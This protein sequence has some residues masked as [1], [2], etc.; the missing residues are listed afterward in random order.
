MMLSDTMFQITLAF[1]CVAA[2]LYLWSLVGGPNATSRG[3]S[4]LAGAGLAAQT[5]AIVLR[6]LETGHP[7]FINLFE[8]L[9][10]VTWALVAIYL[11]TERK[12]KIGGLGAFV[13]TVALVAIVCGSSLP[14]GV[15]A[16]LMAAI[17][18]R[19]SS[20]HIASC[21]FSYA[22]FALAF[23]AAIGYILQERLLKL[24]RLT[25]FQQHL[26]SLDMMDRFAYRM[27]AL[28]FPMLT[29]GVVT[30]A[31][32]ARTAWGDYWSWD[33]KETWSLVTWLVYAAY[34]HVRIVQGW[35]G[36]W[37][38]RLI[39]A[40]FACM[41]MTYFGVSFLPRGLHRYNW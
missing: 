34:L 36:K 40:G 31:M 18:N 22:S 41:L 2:A 1:Y 19:W 15:S 3:A 25:V 21:L 39:I 14:R 35:R 5:I 20:I 10:V 28:G 24:R 33:P 32:W 11:A 7:P 30:G 9:T 23:A 12:Y 16:G 6:G 8:T 27:V 37:A 26:P 38:N 29:L 13:C 4:V 17:E